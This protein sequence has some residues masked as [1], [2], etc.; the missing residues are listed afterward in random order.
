MPAIIYL[1]AVF[2]LGDR[3]SLR[4][5]RPVSFQHRLA[6]SFIVGLLIS[7]C[8]TYLGSLAAA[9]LSEPLWIGNIVFAATVLIAWLKLRGR[10][11][12]GLTYSAGPRPVGKALWDYI[13]LG[14]YGAFICWLVFATLGVRE[15]KILI[16]FRGWVDFGANLSVMQSFILGHNFPTEHP[17]FPG[18]I[19]RYHFLFWFQA[20]NLEFLGLNPVWSVNILSVLSLIALIILIMT[21]AEVLFE[22]RAVGRIAGFLFFFHSSLGYLGF[23]KAQGNVRAAL[24]A[25]VHA[26]QFIP[27]GYTFRGEDWGGLLIEVFAYQRHLASGIS[28][29]LIVVIFLIE[30]SKSAFNPDVKEANAAIPESMAAM[31]EPTTAVPE[32]TAAIPESIAAIPE[33]DEPVHEHAVGALEHSATSNTA[34]IESSGETANESASNEPLDA[35]TGPRKGFL[36]TKY[37]VAIRWSELGGYIFCGILVGALPFWNGGVFVAALILLL[38]WVVIFP[39]RIYTSNLIIV[40]LLL[41]T[42]QLMLLRSGHVAASSRPEFY[43]GYVMDHPTVKLV[44]EY[45]G[46][47]FGFKWLALGIALLLLSGFHRRFFLAVS[48]LL[49]V[50]FLFRLST[51]AFNNHKLL[52]IWEIFAGIYGAYAIWRIAELQLVG[53]F[54][55]ICLA[56]SLTIGGMIDIFPMKND[57]SLDVPYRDDPLCNWLVENTRPSDVFLSQTLLTHPILT[58]GRK[59]FLGYTLFAWTAGYEVG[60]REKIYRRLFEEHN[61]VD[62]I[63][64]L[65]VNHIAYVGIDDGVRQNHAITNL[66]ESTYKQ[67]FEMVFQ[68]SGGKYANLVIY[69][70]PSG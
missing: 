59:I 15:G 10:P 3:L 21:L 46:W 36:P 60:D 26:K 18:E 25:I 61:P 13:F 41:A 35:P 50:V 70:V 53:K 31:P 44:L 4:F 58:T 37:L 51:D 29:L 11:Y 34:S 8:V 28:V 56:A 24:T 20:A 64:L 9:P 63:R 19:I 23:L 48:S 67:N 30:R 12:P 42:P 62:L 68:D 2:Y 16:P 49:A 69:K 43:F 17:Y 47:T 52:N 45:L 1:V 54:L 66:N 32:S 55:A 65:H 38:S 7:S 40:A 57:I 22:S 33:S 6:T 39:K 27:T 14:I 5:Y